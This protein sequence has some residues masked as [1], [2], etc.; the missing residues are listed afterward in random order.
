MV[1]GILEIESG[2]R[3]S[4]IKVDGKEMDLVLTGACI[5]ASLSLSYD[6]VSQL[7]MVF[8]DPDFKIMHTGIF[9]EPKTK[10][11]SAEGMRTFITYEGLEFAMTNL[12]TETGPGGRGQFTIKARSKTVDDLKRSVGPFVM[13][14]ASPTDFI[15]HE[16]ERV[17]GTFIGQESPSRGAIHRDVVKAGEEWGDSKP[18]SWTT[19]ERLAGEEGFVVFEIANTVYFGKPT[20]FVEKR[21]DAPTAILRWQMDDKGYWPEQV[22]NCQFSTDDEVAWRFNFQVPVERADEFLPGNILDFD[23]IEFFTGKYLVT[24]LDYNLGGGPAT[25]SAQNPV[26]PDP[27][28]DLNAGDASGFLNAGSTNICDILT[29]AGWKGSALKQAIKV[30]ECE[31]GF[32]AKIWSYTHCCVGLFQINMDYH[33]P[34]GTEAMKD[35]L[36]NAKEALRM[37]KADGWGPWE[38]SRSCWEG[39]TGSCNHK[40]KNYAG[41]PGPK[42]FDISDANK[43]GKKAI[44]WAQAQ[45]NNPSQ[46]WHNWCLLFVEY[47]LRAGGIPTC[48][49][50]NA[51]NAWFEASGR[52]GP[53]STP[54]PGVPVYWGE[55]DGHIALSIGNGYCITTDFCHVGKACVA[56]INAI[57]TGWNKPYRGWSD[58]FCGRK[59]W[60]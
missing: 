42:G 31:S 34:G 29:A 37:Y 56:K 54:P 8:A 13:S 55:G 12:D 58:H 10:Y 41:L 49:M 44:A 6:A 2:N 9:G 52:H 23:G 27:L 22:P 24:S 1:A 18:S 4:R 47:A 48:S 45:I 16:T 20:W 11:D 15:R 28:K 3:L 38:A 30:V 5:D 50:G 59:V 7:T 40:V 19:F 39:S 51:N 25:V 35:A 14:G 60:P 57:T 33:H 17:G 36:L 26:N 46:N 21:E 53:Q 43:I 32:D